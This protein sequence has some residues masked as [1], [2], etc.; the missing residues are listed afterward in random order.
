MKATILTFLS[1][2]ILSFCFGQTG[3][4]IIVPKFGD[5]YSECVEQLELGNTDINYKE[6]RESFIESAQFKIASSKSIEFKSMKK[7]LNAL[8]DQEKISRH[9]FAYKTDAKH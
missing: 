2:F 9:H 3:R 8:I 5:K 1:Y 7:E 4:D 6:F